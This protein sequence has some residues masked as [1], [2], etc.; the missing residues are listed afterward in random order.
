M[1][2]NNSDRLLDEI[3]LKVIVNSTAA[4]WEKCIKRK[5]GSKKQLKMF[6]KCILKQVE[7]LKMNVW[8]FLKPALF[9]QKFEKVMKL[10]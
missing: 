9:Y 6:F 8:L 10:A 1:K 5:G 7:L 2:W 3:F 4:N